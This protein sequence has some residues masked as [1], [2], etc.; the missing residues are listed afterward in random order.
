[1]TLGRVPGPVP[2][3]LGGHDRALPSFLSRLA[4]PQHCLSDRPALGPHTCLQE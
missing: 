4:H 3:V 1:M 2:R